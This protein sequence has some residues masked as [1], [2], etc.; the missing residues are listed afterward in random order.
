MLVTLDDRKIRHWLMLLIMRLYHKS[1]RIFGP[2]GARISVMT[3]MYI[4]IHED[5]VHIYAENREA[6]IGHCH[7]GS[8]TGQPVFI[9][10]VVDG[11]FANS[12]TVFGGQG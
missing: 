9:E 12:E 3:G 7:F 10:G 1:N 4:M 8:D 2:E 5:G 6:L 11:F